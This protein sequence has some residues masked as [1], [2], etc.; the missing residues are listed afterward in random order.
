[1]TDEAHQESA[2]GPEQIHRLEQHRRDNRRAVAELGL[3][4]Y[5]SKTPGLEALA[6][7]AAVAPNTAVPIAIEVPTKPLL[8]LSFILDS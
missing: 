7:A 5:G 4:P 1:M 3:S 2:P 6:P 8:L